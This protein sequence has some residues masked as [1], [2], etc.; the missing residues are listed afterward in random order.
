MSIELISVQGL[1]PLVSRAPW[2]AALVARWYFTAHRLAGLVY[3][4][5][6]PRHESAR[7]DL[8]AVAAFQLH[9][10]LINLSPFELEIEQANFHFW[11]GGT[12]LEAIILKKERIAP[13]AST[14]LF[15]SGSVG[16]GQANQIAKLH[17]QN[18]ASLDGNIEFKCL[19]R[20]FAKQVGQLSGVQVV[21]INEKHRNP[22]A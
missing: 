5:L 15:L 11:I 9:V 8:G 17:K 3:V 18:P 10:Q 2:L 7:V 22:D 1:W 14:S 4:D 6:Y 21:V 19:V 16:D 13:G 12:K 20:S